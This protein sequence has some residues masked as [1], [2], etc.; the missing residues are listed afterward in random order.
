MSLARLLNTAADQALPRGRVLLTAI[1][2]GLTYGAVMGS[3]NTHPG[4]PA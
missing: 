1:A 3:F 4:G 2:L